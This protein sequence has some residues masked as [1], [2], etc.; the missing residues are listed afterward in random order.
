MNSISRAHVLQPFGDGATMTALRPL[1]ALM[2]LLAGVAPGLVDGVTAQT[3]PTGRAISTMPFAV[4]DGDHADRLRALQVAQQ[5][6]RLAMVLA[7]SCRRRCRCRWPRPRAR[8][9]RGCGRLDDRPAG[10]RD[11]RVD[12]RPASSARTMRCAARARATSASTSRRLRCSS[13]RLRAMRLRSR[14]AAQSVLDVRRPWPAWPSGRA[15]CRRPCR[16]PPACRRRLRCPAASSFSRMSGSAHD[17][18]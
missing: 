9:A 18:R 13:V 14:C 12:L 10:G 6:E 8:R 11:D 15:R 3:T 4:V 17:R 1:S 16:A 2:I 5:A 7:R